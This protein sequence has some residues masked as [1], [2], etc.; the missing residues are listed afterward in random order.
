M[1]QGHRAFTSY[2]AKRGANVLD[3]IEPT[4][5]V[6][7]GSFAWGGTRVNVSRTNRKGDLPK[8]EGIEPARQLPHEELILVHRD[9]HAGSNGHKHH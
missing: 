1:G 3:I 5:E 6:I 2:A 9:H 7:T 8:L 4:E